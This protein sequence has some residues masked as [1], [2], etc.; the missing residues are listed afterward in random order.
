[1]LKGRHNGRKE[2]HTHTR[3]HLSGEEHI[4]LSVCSFQAEG[5]TEVTRKARL[6]LE[7]TESFFVDVQRMNQNLAGFI[8]SEPFEPTQ[9]EENSAK[10]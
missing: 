8:L 6:Y 1:M 9:T 7:E 3:H 2:R 4:G 10:A 5:R